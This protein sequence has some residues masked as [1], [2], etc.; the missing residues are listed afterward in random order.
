MNLLFY[1]EACL[2]TLVYDPVN[3]YNHVENTKLSASIK[4][5][6]WINNWKRYILA[7]GL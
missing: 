6:V 2:K 7:A 5:K 3:K 4:K 1:I